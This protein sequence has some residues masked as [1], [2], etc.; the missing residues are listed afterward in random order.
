[1]TYILLL[2]I[3]LAEL[4]NKQKGTF[5]SEVSRF[6]F[7]QDFDPFR[8]A[9]SNRTE[10]YLALDTE[11]SLNFNVI[12]VPIIFTCFIDTYDSLRLSKFAV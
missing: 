7:T 11:Y 1:M 3:D 5:F 4:N 6:I 9:V 10:V 8:K 12:W 2:E